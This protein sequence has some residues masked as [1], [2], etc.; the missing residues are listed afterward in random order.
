MTELTKGGEA[1]FEFLLEYMGTRKWSRR[2]EG[3]CSERHV[4]VENRERP[5][6]WR[7]E[8]GCRLGET[9]RK[10]FL[11]FFEKKSFYRE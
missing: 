2:G 8:R 9:K 4:C 5:F 6:G 1:G 7:S 11:L 10:Q 3:T